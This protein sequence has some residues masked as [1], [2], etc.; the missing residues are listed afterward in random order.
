M[1]HLHEA[2]DLGYRNIRHLKSSVA[3]VPLRGRA[4]FQQLIRDLEAR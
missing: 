4:D 2:V 1:D 3:F